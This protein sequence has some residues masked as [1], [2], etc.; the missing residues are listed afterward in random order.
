MNRSTVT[1]FQGYQSPC[2]NSSPEWTVDIFLGNTYHLLLLNSSSFTAFLMAWCCIQWSCICILLTRIHVYKG[3]RESEVPGAVFNDLAFAFYLHV[4]KGKRESKVPGEKLYFTE[5]TWKIL[6]FVTMEWLK[7]LWSNCAF[8][9]LCQVHQTWW[10]NDCHMEQVICNPGTNYCFHVIVV[11]ISCCRNTTGNSGCMEN[12]VHVKFICFLH[13]HWMCCS[14]Q[15]L[16]FFC[17]GS[18]LLLSHT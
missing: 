6:A 3:K 11:G 8:I 4:Y 14:P 2:S 9:H 5:A 17:T 1:F 12:I 16:G 13:E 15:R 18:F 10:G 7:C